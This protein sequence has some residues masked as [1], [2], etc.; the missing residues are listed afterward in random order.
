MKNVL[1][2]KTPTVDALA[3][4]VIAAQLTDGRLKVE[5]ADLTV[6][7]PDYQSALEKIFKADSVAVW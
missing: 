4:Q 3:E 7:K 6:E 2:I 1:H 5:I